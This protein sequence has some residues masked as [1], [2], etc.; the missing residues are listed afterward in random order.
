MRR[1]QLHTH[2][3]L[4][5]GGGGLPAQAGRRR[6]STRHPRSCRGK[7]KTGT[8]ARA[9]RRRHPRMQRYCR[10]FSSQRAVAYS[11]HIT[12]TAFFPSHRALFKTGSE[13]AFI[14]ACSPEYQPSEQQVQKTPP[15]EQRRHWQQRRCFFRCHHHRRLEDLRRL[16]FSFTSSAVHA[17]Q[18]RSAGAN[19]AHE[20]P[21]KDP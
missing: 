19:G 16:E 17:I 3:T 4:R 18:L 20:T 8:R 5:G 14:D 9:R 2:S 21:Q 11:Q 1:S 10:Q 7:T 12:P 13:E 15:C 6:H